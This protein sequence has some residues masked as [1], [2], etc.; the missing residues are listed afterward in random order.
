MPKSFTKSENN[1]INIKKSY[2]S[3][4][5]INSKSFTPHDIVIKGNFGR[6]FQLLLSVNKPV[7]FKAFSYSIDA[8]VKTIKDLDP[9]LT[10]TEIA[11]F[12]PIVK[13]GYG[14][15]KILQ[16]MINKASGSDKQGRPFKLYLY[17]PMLGE[18]YLV[19]PN[20]NSMTL[21]QNEGANN[22]IWEYTLN[23]TAIAPL[24]NNTNKLRNSTANILAAD[25]IRK[26]LGVFVSS[27]RKFVAVSTGNS[28]SLSQAVNVR[29]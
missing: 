24:L 25:N 26:G 21:M 6:T 16:F 18:S 12:N 2:A 7:N 9:M 23:L 13:T 19:V 10:K 29:L 20:P 1:R 5:V 17:N 11:T 28:S 27:V 4:N 14:C 22:M 15:T 3:V 8:G